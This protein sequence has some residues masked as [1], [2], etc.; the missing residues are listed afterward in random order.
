MLISFTRDQNLFSDFEFTESEVKD[1]Q[2]NIV[3]EIDSDGGW[4]LYNGIKVSSG[5]PKKKVS[6]PSMM[7]MFIIGFAQ[8]TS[9][10]PR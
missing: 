10:G 6:L 4:S 2:G 3:G 8:K 7:T 1:K 5:K 9:E